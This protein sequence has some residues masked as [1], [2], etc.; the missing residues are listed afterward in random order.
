MAKTV[1][2]DELH[3]TVRVPATCPRRAE[4]VRRTLARVTSSWTGC[5]G[6]S[7][8]RSCV[9][10]VARRLLLAGPLITASRTASV[11]P[12]TDVGA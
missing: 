8:T 3:L 6:L 5:G 12:P 11:L 10:G 4:A 1:V 9:P 2:I 7:G